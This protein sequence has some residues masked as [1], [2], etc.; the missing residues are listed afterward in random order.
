MHKFIVTASCAVA[1]ALA[2]V[3]LGPRQALVAQS[4]N[5][6]PDPNAGVLLNDRSDRR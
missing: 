5:P 1:C 6:Y 4:A 3:V 2:V